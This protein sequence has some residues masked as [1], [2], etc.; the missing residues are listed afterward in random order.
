MELARWPPLGPPWNCVVSVPVEGLRSWPACFVPD[1][2]DF[3]DKESGRDRGGV[4]SLRDEAPACPVPR[5]S[6]ASA[7]RPAREVVDARTAPARETKVRLF[8][9]EASPLSEATGSLEEDLSREGGGESLGAG[10]A[11][12]SLT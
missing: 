2:G 7:S 12:A 6:P 9:G 8:P 5:A 1:F 3:N 4:S 10:V 11:A